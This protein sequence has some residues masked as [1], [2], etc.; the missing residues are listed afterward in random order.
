MHTTFVSPDKFIMKIDSTIYLIILIMHHKYLY[1][2]YKISQSCF[3][4]RQL[5]KETEEYQVG[6][7][8][9]GNYLHL[10][11]TRASKNK[12]HPNTYPLHI[13][14]KKSHEYIY[15]THKSIY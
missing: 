12:P 4:G 7:W 1:F 5:F 14:P 2:L 10:S 9:R 6:S 3:S 13:P 11:F 8:P 15:H